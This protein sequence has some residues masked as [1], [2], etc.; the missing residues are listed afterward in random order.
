MKLV[1]LKKVKKGDLIKRTP[2]SKKVYMKS[3]YNRHLKSFIC[4]DW[5]DVNRWLIIKADK[6]VYTGFTF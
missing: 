5:D 6:Q 2:D 1:P 4:V 3:S